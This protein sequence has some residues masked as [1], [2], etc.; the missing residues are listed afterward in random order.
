MMLT[1]EYV[2]MIKKEF[3]LDTHDAILLIIA[4][5]LGELC[6]L[7]HYSDITSILYSNYKK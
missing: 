3:E 2:E 5:R 4:N 7:R 1:K 6:Y